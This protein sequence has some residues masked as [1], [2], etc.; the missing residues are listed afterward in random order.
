MAILAALVAAA[1]ILA[2]AAA[3]TF[4][5]GAT[6][7]WAVGD[8][9][10]GS[11][12]ARRV[13]EMIIDE[14]P[15]LFLYLGDIYQSPA[16]TSEEEEAGEPEQDGEP[17]SETPTKD[18]YGRDYGALADITEA[19]PGNHEWDENREEY[20]A[21]WRAAKGREKPLWNAVE[22][23]GW[24]I[25]NLNSE[26]SLEDGSEQIRW[27]REQ[28]REPGTCRIA[29]VHLPRFSA[30][31]NHGDQEQVEPIWQALRGH[32]VMV[33]SGNDHDMQR[34]KPI[35]GM[36]QFV[37]GSG[38]RSHY[39]VEDD[40]RLAFSDDDHDGALRLELR[41][42][43]AQHSFVSTEGETL[44]SGEIECEELKRN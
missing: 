4:L 14:D 31:S 33:L 5:R 40:D 7:V 27:L 44:D 6:V 17:E 36:V 16:Y 9:A 10:D 1:L 13:A 22:V 38:G 21:W 24:E 37:S 3:L 32:A 25:L 28:V 34:F 18:H 23:E 20:L 42:G 29:I 41:P 35:D 15:D 26:E 11:S 30:S 2:L 43:S 19:T 8:S 12:D 39:G